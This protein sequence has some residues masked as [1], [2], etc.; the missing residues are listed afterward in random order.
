MNRLVERFLFELQDDPMPAR[1]NIAPSQ[2]VAALRVLPPADGRHLSMLRW[3][4]IPSWAKDP[5][6]AY[7]LINARC[8]TVAEKP[9]FRNAL[10]HR[11]CLILA[12]G[13]YEWKKTGKTAKQPYYIH[14][15]DA[16]PFAFAGLWE[17]WQAGDGSPLET[18]TIITT[19]SNDLTKPIH[20][21]M[22]VILAAADYETWLSAPAE[23]A[24]GLTELLRAYPPDQMALYPVSTLVNSPRNE[25]AKCVV[26][27]DD[28]DDA[29]PGEPSQLKF[30]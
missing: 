13:Y 21:R 9:S 26:P 7:K 1:F 28:P 5:S 16:Q 14:M 12:D 8:E 25:S 18:C 22:P 20:P 4:L 29:S 24:A 19:E 30:L 23:N 17:S 11:R 6:I 3:G 27:L 10:K 2:P 15:R